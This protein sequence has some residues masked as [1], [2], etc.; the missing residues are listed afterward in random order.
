MGEFFKGLRRKVGLLTL[1]MALVFMGGWVR[2]RTKLD[3]ISVNPT[4]GQLYIWSGWEV[5]C[6]RMVSHS[7]Y[8]NKRPVYWSWCDIRSTFEWRSVYA[9]LIGGQDIFEL[10]AM[11][12]IKFELMPHQKMAEAIV[13][14]FN[15]RE[16]SLKDAITLRLPY[17]SITVSLTLLSAFL[18]LTKP[19]KSTQMKITEPSPAEGT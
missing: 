18:L 5:I 9:P 10:N 3:T 13:R 7:E 1:L 12:G 15:T 2:S 17:W 19:R 11:E 8:E 6:I 14:Q 16:D 4:F